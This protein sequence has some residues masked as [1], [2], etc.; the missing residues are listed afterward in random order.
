MPLFLYNT[1]DEIAVGSNHESRRSCILNGFVL[2]IHIE[3]DMEC[4][5][6][7]QLASFPPPPLNNK[8]GAR[9][10]AVS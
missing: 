3:S 8:Y 5:N 6:G 9:R 10:G 2:N 7:V 4:L 1:N